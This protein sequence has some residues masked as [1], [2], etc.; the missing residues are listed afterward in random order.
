MSKARKLTAGNPGIRGIAWTR[1]GERILFGSDQDGIGWGIWQ[2]N[3]NGNY[4][5]QSQ[6]GSSIATVRLISLFE[7]GDREVCTSSSDLNRTFD[8]S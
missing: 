8:G 6:L 7:L 3:V 5:H 2:V 1:D 4:S